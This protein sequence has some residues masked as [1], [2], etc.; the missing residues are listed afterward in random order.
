M[1][2]VVRKPAFSYAKTK[3]QSS[4]NR[5]ADQRLSP[6]FTIGLIQFLYYLN[7]KFQASSNLVWLYSPVCVGPGRKHRRPVF[8]Q[9]GSNKHCSIAPLL[10]FL[11]Y[12]TC[13][14]GVCL[15]MTS[16]FTRIIYMLKIKFYNL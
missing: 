16:M 6:A 14:C 8:S 11:S 1:S 4:G 10:P 15:Y 12:Y 3:T 9:R 2:R 5:E 13:K 7:L